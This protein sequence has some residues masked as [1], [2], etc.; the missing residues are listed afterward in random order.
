MV[1]VTILAHCHAVLH[2]YV[3]LK[4][5]SG[6]K[7]PATCHPVRVPDNTFG[8][9]SAQ[10]CPAPQR[11]VRNF[12]RCLLG[13]EHPQMVRSVSPTSR[14]RKTANLSFEKLW[15]HLQALEC[16]LHAQ[17][18]FAHQLTMKRIQHFV[19]TLLWQNCSDSSNAY[20]LVG[21]IADITAQGS[22]VWHHDAASS[23][24]PTMHK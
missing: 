16:L 22:I 19:G 5:Q 13:P 17:H 1:V 23:F 4:L 10:K 18:V 6:K 11:C 8:R 2:V 7:I 3:T 12:L 24:N 9:S 14:V 21:G 15:L 20:R